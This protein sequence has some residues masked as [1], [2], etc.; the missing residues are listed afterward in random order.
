VIL[1]PVTMRCTG[2]LSVVNYRDK[3]MNR[4]RHQTVSAT[5]PANTTSGNTAGYFTKGDAIL[6][7]APT[8]PTADWANGIT[9]EMIN[10]ITESG[11]TPSE[12]NLTQLAVAMG[13]LGKR[14]NLVINGNFDIWQRGTTQTANGYG[15]AD[16]WNFSNV[17][18]TKTVTRSAFT[19]GQTD[20]PNAP[21][22]Y[23]NINVTSASGASDYVKNINKISN[24]ALY[25]GKNVTLSFWAKANATKNIA[26][27]FVQNFGSGGSPSA[28]V[29]GI[30]V[31]KFTLSTAWTKYTKT[32]A[33]PSVSGKTLGTDGKD[34]FN[35]QIWLDAGS[36]FNSRTNSLGNQ[37]GIFD[38]AQVQVEEGL[39]AT[40]FEM[41][42]LAEE[43]RLCNRYYQKS[44][45]LETAPAQN[46]GV[47]GAARCTSTVAGAAANYGPE[48]IFN[49]RMH[50]MPTVTLYNPSAANAQVRNLNTGAD[51]SASAASGVTDRSFYLDYT[52]DAGGTVGA[53]CIV[54]WS[55]SAEI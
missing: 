16:R 51:C 19:L 5:L 7:V 31:E 38:I 53:R 11:Q 46:A 22:Y 12:A 24:V 50:G 9:E 23:A 44:F 55:A 29:T 40:A 49:G 39:H 13:S 20:V 2:L 30:G 47:T 41:R 36:S 28:D 14:K 54:H 27:E 10:A 33:L 3:N 37:S 34:N 52:G 25:A 18:S 35:V 32:V 17:G 8:T 43:L 45:A 1:I 26:V 42:P 21:A 4:N 48:I 15:S 6:G